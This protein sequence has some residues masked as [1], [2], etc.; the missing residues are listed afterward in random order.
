[1]GPKIFSISPQPLTNFATM[2]SKIGTSGDVNTI[3]GQILK[4]RQFKPVFLPK[5]P[6]NFNAVTLTGLWI[7]NDENCIVAHSIAGI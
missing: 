1:M 6:Q 4:I 7:N 2:R 3:V 5:M